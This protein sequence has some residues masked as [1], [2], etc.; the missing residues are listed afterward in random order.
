MYLGELGA[1][2]VGTGMEAAV[3][4]AH[5]AELDP[6]D[7][8]PQTPSRRVTWEAKIL[9]VAHSNSAFAQALSLLVL[10]AFCPGLHHTPYADNTLE[11][12]YAKIRAKYARLCTDATENLDMLKTRWP[13]YSAFKLSVL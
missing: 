10:T 2:E 3:K 8:T 11:P 5:I 12:L 13:A 9:Q 1:R 6:A 4:Q 7:E